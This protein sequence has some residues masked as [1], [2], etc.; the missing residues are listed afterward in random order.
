LE[1]AKLYWFLKQPAKAVEYVQLAKK[2]STTKEELAEVN[3]FIE[4]ALKSA[5]PEQREKFN[6]LISK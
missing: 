1:E 4:E 3:K 2:N 5:T 6:S